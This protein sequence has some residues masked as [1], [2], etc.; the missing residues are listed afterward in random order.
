MPNAELTKNNPPIT[1]HPPA[2]QNNLSNG[3]QTVSIRLEIMPQAQKQSIPYTIFK[4]TATENETSATSLET[5]S[6]PKPQ[7]PAK[8]NKAQT[9][10][11]QK[12]KR[13]ASTRSMI[14][15]NHA[16]LVEGGFTYNRDEAMTLAEDQQ[17]RAAFKA[18]I[19]DLTG[20]LE[21]LVA[22]YQSV[23]EK[24]NSLLAKH[25]VST[26]RATFAPTGKDLLMASK[27]APKTL[28]NYDSSNNC[29]QCANCNPIID[30]SNNNNKSSNI[31]TG[32]TATPT[33]TSYITQAKK[34]ID[35][36][37][38]K[39]YIKYQEMRK[40]L[41]SFKIPTSHI[42]DIQFPAR[43][44]VA[45]L[46]NGEF[47]KEL[48]TLLE[49]AKVTP[50]DNFDPTATDVIA[51]PK[52]KEEFIEAVMKISQIA[53]SDYLEGRKTDSTIT[54]TFLPESAPAIQCPWTQIHNFAILTTSP[55][56]MDGISLLIRPDFP[57]H[58]HP[59]PIINPHV[60][61][62]RIDLYTIHCVYLPPRL[63]SSECQEWLALLPIHDFTIVCG[64]F[65]A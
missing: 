19:A 2:H 16:N 35:A 52:L 23:M 43:G 34:G 58:V 33:Q 50:L 27:H 7:I 63:T 24:L 5:N 28:M 44:T 65:N 54:T 3:T 51:D 37:Q 14:N 9:L 31:T 8:R 32:S 26:T 61:S 55:K 17:E 20:R 49:K 38:A 21:K 30:N 12:Q 36:K 10:A 46:I 18:T 64:D 57:H 39:Q 15:K 13:A 29:T 59:L 40:I 25:N 42:L 60:V 11:I 56:P 1:N 41:S 48:I 22:N 45:L 53:V 47:C 62:C 6:L 4:F